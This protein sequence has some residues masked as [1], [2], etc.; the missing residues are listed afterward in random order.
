MDKVVNNAET[1]RISPTLYCNS[2]PG[3]K[4]VGLACTPLELFRHQV[5]QGIQV[6]DA[7]M[8]SGLCASE[9]I[10]TIEMRMIRSS[11]LPERNYYSNAP[12]AGLAVDRILPV[13]EVWSRS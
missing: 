10:R 2:V 4:L 7:I 1:K 3:E 9:T 5:K 8:Q 13:K 12:T 11:E 6:I